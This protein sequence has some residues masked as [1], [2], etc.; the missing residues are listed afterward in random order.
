[1]DSPKPAG[2]DPVALTRRAYESVNT[3]DYD[4]I[5]SFFAE[6]SVWDVSRLGLGSHTGLKA[7]RHFLE[8]WIDSFDE[9]EMEIEDV[10]G[11]PNGVVRVIANIVARPSGSSSHVRLQYAPVLLW[12][13]GVAMSLT[14]YLDIEESRRAAE[15]LSAERAL[16]A[17]GRDAA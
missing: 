3:R 12:V 14:H 1:M 10:F 11:L 16:S 8:D 2:I 6:D 5:I 4:A 15:Q 17:G 13:D 9:Y 7:I